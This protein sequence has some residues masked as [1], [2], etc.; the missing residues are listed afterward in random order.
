MN[1]P[2]SA[3]NIP[4]CDVMFAWMCNNADLVHGDLSDVVKISASRN[5][6]VRKDADEWEMKNAATAAATVAK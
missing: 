6:E 1:F 5:L 4:G 2:E 3:R